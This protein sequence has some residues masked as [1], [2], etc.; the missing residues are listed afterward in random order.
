MS[1]TVTGATG[2]TGTS[3]TTSAITGQ[4]SNTLGQDA[5]LR[6]LVTEL[7]HQDPSKP[8]DNTEYITQLATFSQLEQL[9][10]ISDSVSTLTSI[11]EAMTRLEDKVAALE[12]AIKAASSSASGSGS[13]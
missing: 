6:L 3:D 4:K 12:T 11:S 2:A 10:S 5:F 9:T 1:T 7:T 8:M 13:A